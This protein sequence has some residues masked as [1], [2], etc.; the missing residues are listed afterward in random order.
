MARLGRSRANPVGFVSGNLAALDHYVAPLL[1]FFQTAH[2]LAESLIL[3]QDLSRAA[4]LAAEV[5]ELGVGGTR[6]PDAAVQPALE[7]GVLVG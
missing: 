1:K 3:E 6:V 2:E 7:V 5:A 4:D